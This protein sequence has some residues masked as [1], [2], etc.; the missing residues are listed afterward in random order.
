MENFN[1]HVRTR[2]EFGQA[3]IKHCVPRR[4]LASEE[5]ALPAPGSLSSKV[6]FILKPSSEV[7]GQTR[8]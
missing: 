5:D 7:A 3:S 6:L 2:V 8:K 1:F 4:D